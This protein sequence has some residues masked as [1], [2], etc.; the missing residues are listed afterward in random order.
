MTTVPG[1]AAP[2]AAFPST[3][4]AA[5]SWVLNAYAIVFAAL[6]IAAGRIADLVGRGSQERRFRTAGV[7]SRTSRARL[8]R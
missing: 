1:V 8:A 6:L 4:R 3:T 5:L 2:A 7:N